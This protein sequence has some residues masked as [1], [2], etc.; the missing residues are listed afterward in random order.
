[1]KEIFKCAKAKRSFYFFVRIEHLAGR[2]RGGVYTRASTDAEGSITNYGRWVLFLR[3]EP[4][5]HSCRHHQRICP[6][7]LYT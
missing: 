4:N 6:L 3:A 1:M 7:Y 5:F 2:R